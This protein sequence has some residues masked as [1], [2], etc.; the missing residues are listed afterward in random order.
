MRLNR[1]GFCAGADWQL[2]VTGNTQERP[3]VSLPG[4]GWTELQTSCQCHLASQGKRRSGRSQTTSSTGSVP[5]VAFRPVN[6]P[7]EGLSLESHGQSCGGICESLAQFT[8]LAPSRREDAR[9][10]RGARRI[11]ART[12]P[13]GRGRADCTLPGQ[14]KAWPRGRCRSRNSWCPSASR[15]SSRR[16][17]TAPCSGWSR[18]PARSHRTGARG[19]RSCA[20]SCWR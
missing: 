13:A 11:G 6:R 12:A 20:H 16:R 14:G 10:L 8:L 3:F 18:W 7:I 5:C 17:S 19:R 2:L 4:N 15:L 9:R 1:T